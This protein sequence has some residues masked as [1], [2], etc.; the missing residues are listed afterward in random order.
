MEKSGFFQFYMFLEIAENHG[1]IPT[2]IY[3]VFGFSAGL[4][5]QDL[6]FPICR[7]SEKAVLKF[8]TRIFRKKVCA[9]VAKG[10]LVFFRVVLGKKRK[11]RGKNRAKIGKIFLEE[12]ART[13]IRYIYRMSFSLGF[14]HIGDY[15]KALKIVIFIEYF[16]D[17]KQWQMVL[18]F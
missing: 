15:C 11:K 5:R 1:K 13:E 9:R 8:P 18:I 3:K 6:S 14:P 4:F 10:F 2:K 7:Q 17:Y 12:R 16:S